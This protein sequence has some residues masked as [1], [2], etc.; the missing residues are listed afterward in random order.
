MLLFRLLPGA[1]ALLSD[2]TIF[3]YPFDELQVKQMERELAATKA[4]FP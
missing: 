4:V 3:F 2:L 1:F